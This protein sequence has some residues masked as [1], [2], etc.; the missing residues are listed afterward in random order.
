ML[1][2]LRVFI[3]S[4]KN[5]RNVSFLTP[6]FFFYLEHGNSQLCLVHMILLVSMWE[7]NVDSLPF[8]MSD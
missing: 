7:K 1:N 5:K 6:F 4:F 3:Q 8:I 2:M